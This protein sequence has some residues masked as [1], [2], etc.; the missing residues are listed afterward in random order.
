M[1][2]KKQVATKKSVKRV[3]KGGE[4]EVVD[5]MMQPPPPP[6]ESE[7]VQDSGEDVEQLSA[8]VPNSAG[9]GGAMKSLVNSYTVYKCSTGFSGG[10]YIS[11]NPLSAA[12]KAA[13]RAFKGTRSNTLTIVLKQTTSGSKKKFYKYEATRETLETPVVVVL[14]GNTIEYKYNIEVKAMD[15]DKDLVEKMEQKKASIKSRSVS[16][17]SSSASYKSKGGCCGKLDL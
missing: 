2:N 15:L 9:L 1:A 4:G 17:K 11:A 7:E 5:P 16:S 14:D 3:K 8:V 12:K 13:S 10:R 6:V